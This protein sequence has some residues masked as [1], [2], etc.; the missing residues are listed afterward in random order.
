MIAGI[1]PG[2]YSDFSDA[3]IE[4]A[5]WKSTGVSLTDEELDFIDLDDAYEEIFDQALGV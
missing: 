4:E 3:Y 5:C 2:D 1:N